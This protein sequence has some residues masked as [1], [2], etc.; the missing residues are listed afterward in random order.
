LRPNHMVGATAN[1]DVRR[2]MM[3]AIDQNEVMTA[4]MGEDRSLF[5]APVGYFLPGTPSANDAG[6][7]G[8]RKRR[9]TAEVVRMLKDAGYNNERVVLLHPTDQPFY[10]AATYVVAAALQ[11]IGINLDVQQVDW[12]T[13]VQR[14]PSKE[15]LEKG[16]WSLFPAGYPAG[17]YRDPISA[18]NI[19]GNGAGA[20]FGWPD[21]PVLEG[22]RDRWMDSQDPAE[23]SRLDRE[24]QSRAF[25]TVPFIPLGQYMP[26]AAWRRSLTGL[27]KGPLPVF[28]NVSKA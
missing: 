21:D 15:P 10:N 19:R 26:S 17:E 16:G 12:G 27:L 5:R 28:W 7:D 3:A 6:M 23:Q 4:V 8:V 9:S 18:T 24:I 1:V 14:R 2:A 22:M 20:W 13:V 25:E 11:K